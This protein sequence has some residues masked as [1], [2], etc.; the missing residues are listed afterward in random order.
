M[1]GLVGAAEMVRITAHT[2]M[3]R[4]WSLM[5]TEDDAYDLMDNIVPK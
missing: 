4:W 5:I 1:A 2:M 3:L